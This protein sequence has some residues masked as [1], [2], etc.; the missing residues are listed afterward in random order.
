MRPFR[1]L[2]ALCLALAALPGPACTT[3]VISGKATPDGRPILWKNRDTPDRHNQVVRGDGGR[4]SFVGVANQADLGGLQIWS[5]VNSAGFAIMNNVSYNVDVKEEDS[6]MEGTFMRLALET[7]G[8]VEDFQALLAATDGGGRFVAANFGVIDAKGGAAYFEAN[9]KRF[10]RF[11]AA[12]APGGFLVRGN[13]SHSGRKG[14]GAGYIREA[15]AQDLVGG[16]RAKNR[17]TVENL[18]GEVARDTANARTGAYPAETG[19]GW[20]WIGDSINRNTTASAYVLQGVLPGED[21][22]ASTAW[23]LLGQPI[24]GVAVPVWVGGGP[25][26]PELHARPMAPLHAAFDRIARHAYPDRSDDQV[27]YLDVARM[28]DPARGLLAPLRDLERRNVEEV[29]KAGPKA[30][31]KALQEGIAKRTLEAVLKLLSDRAVPE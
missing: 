17:L 8:S 26:P 3:G 18:L 10:T 16:L 1:A 7:C 2:L 30:D 22:L 24:T 5:G 23:I 19:K 15:R 27:R 6:T 13:Y 14:Q 9:D 21:P 28:Y 25:V 4:Y 31:R 29:R 12:A 20:A 11:D